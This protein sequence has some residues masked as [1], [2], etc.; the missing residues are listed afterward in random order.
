MTRTSFANELGASIRDGSVIIH[1]LRPASYNLVVLFSMLGQNVY[2]ALTV[3]IPTTILAACL[4]TLTVPHTVFQGLMFFV[5]MLMGVLIMCKLVYLT[6]LL[7]F[8]TQATWYLSWYLEAF[9][10]FFGG[11]MVP[12]WFFPEFLARVSEYLPFRYVTYEAIQCFL[13]RV[14]QT[15][16]IRS[17]IIA[18]TWVV[19][20]DCT[21]R[22][23]W[24]SISKKITVNGG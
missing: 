14:T 5:L 11:T 19:V 9:L 8:W 17:T 24:R 12:L 4:F 21:G 2:H 10:V 1:F 7:A 3:A 6:G 18:A 16:M 13:G 20:L 22:L 15:E 23:M